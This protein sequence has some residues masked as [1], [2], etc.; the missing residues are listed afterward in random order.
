MSIVTSIRAFVAILVLAGASAAL[1]REYH[2]SVHGD[3]ASDGS[4]TT[5]LKT[6][7]N[8]SF[9]NADGSPVRIDTDYC[10]KRR[11]AGKPVWDRLFNPMPPAINLGF[12]ADRVHQVLWRIDLGELDG[13]MP[14]R[15]VLMIGAN[16]VLGGTEAPET[17]VQGIRACLQRIR[18]KTPEAKI[19]LM[20]VL[21]CR[22]PAS[23]PDRLKTLRINDGLVALTKEARNDCLDLGPQFLDAQ[24]NIPAA[25]M[26]DAVHPKLSGYQIWGDALAPSLP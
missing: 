10:G 19:T 17:V 5:L 21:P 15:V 1:G 2:V 16:H 18:A 14:Q 22:N 9:E 12:G 3:D 13:L 8:L 7:R 25:L 4:K 23:H 6:I 20:A 26:S 24:G 11:K